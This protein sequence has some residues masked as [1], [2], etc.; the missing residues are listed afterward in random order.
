MSVAPEKHE[1]ASSCG[2][3][4]F[5]FVETSEVKFLEDHP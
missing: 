5:F 2:V 4:R 1:E 3:S